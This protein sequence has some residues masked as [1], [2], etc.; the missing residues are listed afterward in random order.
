M[1]DD[2]SVPFWWVLIFVI[3][4]LGVAAGAVLF[5]G[6]QLLSAGIGV[7]LPV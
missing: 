1:A 5:V 4:T 7:A 2:S 3:L 6:G